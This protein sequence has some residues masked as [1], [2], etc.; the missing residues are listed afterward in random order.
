[1]TEPHEPRP[2]D[3][4]VA[5]IGSLQ[6]PVRRALYRYVAGRRADVSRDEAA[7]AVGVQRSLAAFHLDKLVEAGLLEV[8]YRRLTGR[9]G[10]GAGR[11][12]KLYRRSG[13]EHRVSLPSRQYDL[14]ADLLAQAIEEAGERPVRESVSQVARRFGRRL[15]E[16][17]RA[18]LGPRASRERRLAALTEALDRYGYEP[19]REGRAVRLGNCPF[20][21]LA[22]RHRDVV[23]SM[24]L[25]VL[26]G[27]VDGMEAADIEARPDPQP[28]ECCV[29]LAAKARRA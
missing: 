21:A 20:H 26:E 29:S 25:S 13:V 6:E 28:G 3:D 1:M 22:E 11:P 16:Q 24:N 4:E 9:T 8:T 14:A 12:A 7:E 23:C 10:P 5:T 17:L 2:L 15:G 27:V 18:R 19:R